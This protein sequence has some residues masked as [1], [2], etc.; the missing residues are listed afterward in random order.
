M[1]RKYAEIL[2]KD[3]CKF[4][5]LTKLRNSLKIQT[6]PQEAATPIVNSLVF[7][8]GLTSRPPPGEEG[9][10]SLLSG[11]VS[12]PTEPRDLAKQ[13]LEQRAPTHVPDAA[14]RLGIS[15]NVEFSLS[16][17]T[18]ACNKHPCEATDMSLFKCFFFFKVSQN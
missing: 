11:I 4:W 17:K 3:L 5:T 8:S 6:L 7:S 1:E 14:A 13:L 18:A 16:S 15:R 2:L 9:S 10:D 12:V